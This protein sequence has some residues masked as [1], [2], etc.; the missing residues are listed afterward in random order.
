MD[1]GFDQ[2]F[3]LATEILLV[4][5]TAVGGERRRHR[6]EDAFEFEIGQGLVPSR[7]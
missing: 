2:P 7:L 6:G 4:D 1:T 3:D 5:G